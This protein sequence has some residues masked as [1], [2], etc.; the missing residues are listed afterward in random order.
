VAGYQPVC[1]H[2]FPAA[3]SQTAS[4]SKGRAN[5]QQQEKAQQQQQQQSKTLQAHA[6]KNK[7]QKLPK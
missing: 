5:M 2:G 1:A 4:L 6:G 3:R 7:V